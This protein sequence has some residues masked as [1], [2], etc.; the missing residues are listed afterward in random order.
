VIGDAVSALWFFLC[1]CFRLSYPLA[2][3]EDDLKG[4]LRKVEQEFRIHYL[5]TPKMQF[6]VIHFFCTQTIDKIGEAPILADYAHEKE[7][8]I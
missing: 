7:K 8:L 1:Y 4:V 3:N 2:F 5:D 6:C